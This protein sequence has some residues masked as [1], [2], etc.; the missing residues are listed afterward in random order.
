MA[1]GAMADHIISAWATP[2][3]KLHHSPA[4]LKLG[5]WHDIAGALTH[6]GVHHVWQGCPAKGAWSHAA[7]TDLVHWED[8]GLGPSAI[9]ETYAGMQSNS[10]PCSGFVTL[11]DEGVPCAGFRQCSSTHGTTALNPQANKWDVPLE[12]RC[13]QDD[14]LTQWGAS[15]FLFPYYFYRA[16]PYDP[17]RPWRDDDGKWYTAISSDACN[18]TTRKRPCNAGGQLDLYSAPSFNGTWQKVED[19]P[20]FTTNTSMSGKAIVDK[21]AIDGEFVTS[22][23]IGGLPG[24]PD[25][26]KSRVVTEN[27]NGAH[28]WVGRQQDGPGGRFTPYWERI[29]AVGHYDY[30]SLTMART[31][32]GGA[33]QVSQKGRRVL[34]GWANGAPSLAAQSLPRDLSL[35]PQYELLQAFVPELMSLRSTTAPFLHSSTLGEWLN[36]SSTMQLEVKAEFEYGSSSNAPFGLNVYA[37]PDLTTSTEIFVTCTADSICACGIDARSQGGKRITAPLLF[38]PGGEGHVSLHAIVDGPII[39]LIANNRTAMLVFTAY[40]NLPPAGKSGLRLFG[41]A[42]KASM[43]AWEL[44]V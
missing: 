1:P 21:V 22:D 23:F 27:R 38:Q 36:T 39:E 20:L 34:I 10:C 18:A 13:A 15:Q 35:S 4:C 12:V 16:L 7:S 29:G 17:I 6:K 14:K 26:G 9:Q 41:A 42:V 8:R 3:L 25:G 32:G 37:S 30:G 11:N 2:P 40:K 43:S 19:V 5:G 24:D 31:L 44:E 28:Y 33:N